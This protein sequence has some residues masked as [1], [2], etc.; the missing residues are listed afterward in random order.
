MI[1]DHPELAVAGV[2]A[3]SLTLGGL[4]AVE[5]ATGLSAAR[6]DYLGRVAEILAHAKDMVTKGSTLEVASRWA[7]QARNELKLAERAAGPWFAARAADIMNLIR[8]GNRAGPT[9]DRL[10][11]DLQS[12]AQVLE[13]VGRTNETINRM[14][15]N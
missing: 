13:S 14:T 1:K 7:V 10:F 6:G 15:G 2:A 3:A 12:W 8:Y 11:R 4:A 5:T 9:A